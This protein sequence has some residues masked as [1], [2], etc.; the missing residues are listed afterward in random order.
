MSF[1]G[2]TPTHSLR[3]DTIEKAFGRIAEAVGV[4]C[5]LHSL[6]HWYSTMTAMRVLGGR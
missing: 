5:S 1:E 3:Y 6:R 4:R 2:Q